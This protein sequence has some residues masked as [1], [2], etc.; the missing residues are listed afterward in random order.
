MAI[1]RVSKVIANSS[2][3]FSVSVSASV[4]VCLQKPRDNGL[5]LFVQLKDKRMV[6][7]VLF[8]YSLGI[9]LHLLILLR[10]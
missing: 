6:V 4:S 10:F 2:A 1:V 7:I 8:E 9:T 5:Y 3:M